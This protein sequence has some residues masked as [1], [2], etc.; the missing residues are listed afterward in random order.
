MKDYFGFALASD[1]TSD[2]FTTAS[3]SYFAILGSIQV[4]LNSPQEADTRVVY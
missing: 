4:L 3:V 2:G 1:Y